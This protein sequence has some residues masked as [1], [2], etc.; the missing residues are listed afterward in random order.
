MK[1]GRKNS[2]ILHIPVI[3]FWVIKSI[4]SNTLEK[5]RGDA[6]LFLKGSHSLAQ[7]ALQDDIPAWWGWISNRHP[8]S[9]PC[10]CENWEG[11]DIANTNGS[12]QSFSIKGSRNNINSFFWYT[13]LVWVI[14]W[15]LSCSCSI[16]FWLSLLLLEN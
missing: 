7:P 11:T 12:L 6:L 2:H 15:V 16:V 10:N 3:M 14:L 8:K 4:N 9:N 13:N 5:M 1:W